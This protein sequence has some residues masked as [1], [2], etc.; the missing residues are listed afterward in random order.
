KELRK[1]YWISHSSHG[2]FYYIF[3]SRTF[4]YMA[5][6]IQIYI[7]YYLR[8]C[9]QEDYVKADPDRYTALLCVISQVA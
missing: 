4:Y 8:D 6:S 2:D 9:M 3:V 7:M 5:V 1:S